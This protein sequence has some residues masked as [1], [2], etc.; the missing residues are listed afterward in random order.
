MRDRLRDWRL[1]QDVGD[2]DAKPGEHGIGCNEVAS[3]GEGYH[4]YS[5]A[6]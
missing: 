1:Q 6:A 5:C 3:S 2:V 4:R